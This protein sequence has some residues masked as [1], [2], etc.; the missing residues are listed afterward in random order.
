MVA[1]AVVGQLVLQHMGADLGALRRLRGQIDG[2]PE[3]SEDAGGGHRLGHIHGKQAGGNI[4]HIPPFPKLKGQ[5][6]IAGD[7]DGGHHCHAAEPD[8]KKELIQIQSLGLPD[9]G[10]GFL[11]DGVGGDGP[12]LGGVLCRDLPVGFVIGRLVAVFGGGC[13]DLPHGGG[14]VHLPGHG[15]GAEIAGEELDGHQQPDQHHRP[16]GVLEPQ[17]DPAP[18]QK[19]PQ[20][21]RADQHRRGDDP[22]IHHGDAPPRPFG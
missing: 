8:A 15:A 4:Q 20:K 18:E 13:V 22:L 17:A 1:V 5:M 2:G 21:H 6:D 12:G 9:H 11:F 3:A 14:D 10:V 7:D 19:P 16:Q